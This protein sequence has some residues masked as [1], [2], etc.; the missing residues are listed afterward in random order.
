[1]ARKYLSK[2]TYIKGLQCKKALYL[3][4]F[5]P[6]FSDKISEKQ[7]A[8]FKTGTDI[9]LLA[10]QLFP[11][12]I[13]A[14]PKDYK[15]YFKSFKYTQQL[16]DDDVD[17]IY[18]AGFCYNYVMCFVDILVRSGNKWI[19]Y[20]VKSSTKVSE[21]NKKDAALQYYIMNQCGLEIEDINITYINNT[22]V[23][24]EK[25]DL[26]QLFKSESV[27][28]FA[29]SNQEEV[30]QELINLH[31]VIL[32]N[33]IPNVQIGPQCNSPYKCEF[34]GYCWE[35]VPEYSIFNISGLRSKKKWQLFN[36]D[37]L[38]LKDVPKD[39]PLAKNQRFQVDSH[40]QNISIINREAIN[41]FLDDLS[42][43]LYYL[44][45]ETYQLAVPEYIKMH[46]YQ[47]VPFQYSV[48]I[49]NNGQ[50]HHHEFL[51]ENNKDPREP[52]IQ[53]LIGPQCNSPYKCEFQGYCWE[54]VPEYSIFNISGL[55]SKKS[56]NYLM[57]TFY[58]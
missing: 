30:E 29:K 8:V 7:E 57:M 12:G 17:V 16:I 33:N 24:E 22:Y 6:E 47:Q 25:L 41:D 23:R 2:S 45:F 54:K 50:I 18:E 37:V 44:D 39:F 3:K 20:E 28:S 34:Q 56:G 46:A 53:S 5:H 43:T 40:L 19:A 26:H 1:M 31:E 14:G 32:N 9:G 58:I 52:F 13:D 48:H 27:L 15:E 35:K 55:R 11:N 21:I 51:A 36:D 42:D 49:E 38:Y 4:K 10:Q